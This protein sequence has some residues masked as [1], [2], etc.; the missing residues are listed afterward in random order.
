MPENDVVKD[1]DFH[2]LPDLNQIPS[3]ANVGVTRLGVSR[4]VI[5]G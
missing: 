5:V 4:R 2:N 1:F 3:D